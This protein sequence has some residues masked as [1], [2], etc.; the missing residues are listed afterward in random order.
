[1]PDTPPT[2]PAPPDPA[3]VPTQWCWGSL[4]RGEG[5]HARRRVLEVKLTTISFA[6]HRLPLWA[7]LRGWREAALASNEL[8]SLNNF[9]N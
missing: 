2:A 6:S 3:Q 5:E 1:M 8:W 4:E 7:P 9:H